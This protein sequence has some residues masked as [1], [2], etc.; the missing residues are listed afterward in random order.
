MMRTVHSYG[1][2]LCVL[3]VTALWVQLPSKKMQ[4][5]MYQAPTEA[6]LARLH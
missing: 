1:V 3:T 5:C 6:A 2:A 4:G